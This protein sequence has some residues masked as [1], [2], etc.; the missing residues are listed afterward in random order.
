MQRLS[1]KGYRK[2]NEDIIIE[3]EDMMS[4]LSDR[5]SSNSYREKDGFAVVSNISPSVVSV[6]TRHSE[7]GVIPGCLG[8]NDSYRLFFQVDRFIFSVTV[9]VLRDLFC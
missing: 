7:G 4:T 5:K 6:I 2:I 1:C 9:R 8:D 3:I